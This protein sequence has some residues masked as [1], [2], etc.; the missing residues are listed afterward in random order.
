MYYS[1]VF[2][3]LLRMFPSQ[4]TEIFL[5]SCSQDGSDSIVFRTI[6]IKT[7]T[8]KVIKSKSLKYSTDFKQQVLQFYLFFKISHR[9]RVEAHDHPYATAE[10][11]NMQKHTP[12]QSSR[13]S[14]AA[15]GSC[16]RYFWILPRKINNNIFYRLLFIVGTK[17]EIP[18]NL[19]WKATEVF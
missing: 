5:N 7:R 1:Y 6:S 17:C 14:S 13:L 2:I 16:Q 12:R 19:I 18:S 15:P 3:L 10:E 11:N 4:G 8:R 9:P